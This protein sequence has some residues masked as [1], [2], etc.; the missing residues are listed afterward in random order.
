VPCCC[1]VCCI[2]LTRC[3]SI[4]TD[5]AEVSYLQTI[6]K[7]LRMRATSESLLSSFHHVVFMGDLNYRLDY[8]GGGEFRDEIPSGALVARFQRELMY[9]HSNGEYSSLLQMDQL[10]RMRE[11]GNAFVDFNEADIQFPPTYKVLPNRLIC[12]RCCVAAHF[13]SSSVHVFSEG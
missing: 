12:R 4:L 1:I 6:A 8:G 10:F 13:Q 3:V 9:A 7:E 2:E 11:M 5:Q